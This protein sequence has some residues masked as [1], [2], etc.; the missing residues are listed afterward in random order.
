MN[1]AASRVVWRRI[2]SLHV[3]FFHGTIAGE[4]QHCSVNRTIFRPSSS[5]IGKKSIPHS[6][7][8]TFSDAKFRLE[9]KVTW[10]ETEY[11]LYHV[12]FSTGEHLHSSQLVVVDAYSNIT[13]AWV[14]D[15]QWVLLASTG[16]VH[17]SR[18]H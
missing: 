2:T 15:R 5:T 11:A 7:A 13:S 17:C 8:R 16:L 18:D 6:I 14:S 10:M 1:L 3:R 12:I 9:I 4:V